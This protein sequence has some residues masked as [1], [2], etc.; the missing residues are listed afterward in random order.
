MSADEP[1]RP[2]IR[3]EGKPEEFVE[4]RLAEGKGDL[5]LMV[6]VSRSGFRG[7]I[8]TWV[9][10]ESWMGF[11]QDLTVLES[12]R[13]GQATIESISPEELA[14]TVCSVD[15]AGHMA[16]SGRISVRTFDSEVSLA[17]LSMGFDPSQLPRIAASARGF[18]GARQNLGEVQAHLDLG[19]A[20]AEMGL[21]DDAIH[22][23]ELVLQVWPEHSEARRRLAEL[24]ERRGH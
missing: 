24:R 18:V 8:D 1:E 22:E 13:Q 3:F 2:T 11:A 5:L 4:I 21:I 14:L 23:L 6:A 16:V 17:F 10:R 9:K 7:T 12:R 19:I 20:Y 15:K